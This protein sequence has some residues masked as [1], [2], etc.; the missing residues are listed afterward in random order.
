MQ[1]QVFPD[2]SVKQAFRELNLERDDDVVIASIQSDLTT[3]CLIMLLKGSI[4]SCIHSK[5]KYINERDISY[6]LASTIFPKS[7]KRSRE[8]GYLLDTRQFGNMCTSHLQV[9]IDLLSRHH[10]LQ[11]T[12]VKLSTDS[13]ILLQEATEELIRGFLEYY[14]VEGKGKAYGYRLFDQC[15]STL[16]GEPHEESIFLNHQ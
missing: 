6:A 10:T 15:L 9:L 1:A 3:R 12:D 7:T 11:V 5:R 13:L 4:V 14:A 8:L 2:F 16:L